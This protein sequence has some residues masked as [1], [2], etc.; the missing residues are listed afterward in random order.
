VAEQNETKYW[1]TATTTMEARRRGISNPGS[2]CYLIAP[3]QQL[4]N[5]SAATTLVTG[6]QQ[7]VLA[8]DAVTRILGTWL[9]E[10]SSPEK[11]CFLGLRV[12]KS[13]Y[14]AKDGDIHTQRDAAEFYGDLLR[15]LVEECTVL[16]AT[17]AQ[18]WTTA[19]TGRL[20]NTLRAVDSTNPSHRLDKE[21][22]FFYISVSVNTLDGHNTLES[23]LR[24]F[25]RT[26][27]VPFK[28]PTSDATKELGPPLPTGKTTKFKALPQLLAFHL[29]RFR[30]D[31]KKM[32]KEKLHHRFEFPA[33]LDMRP[34][35]ETDIRSSINSTTG[36]T[37]VGNSGDLPHAEAAPLPTGT[38]YR[39]S[40]VVVH[41]GR[42]AYSGHYYS[43][44]R[45]R[46]TTP[47]SMDSHLGT[48]GALEEALR[49]E[50]WHCYDDHTVTQCDG[51]EL[52]REAFGGLWSPAPAPVPAAPSDLQ[53]HDIAEEGEGNIDHTAPNEEGGDG[54]SS[55]SE[56]EDSSSSESDSERSDSCSESSDDDEWDNS[57]SAP[58][59]AFMLFYDRI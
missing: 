25:T 5:S 22:R 42:S 17:E 49:G 4:L 51:S 36:P 13:F 43:Y 46:H 33:L 30:F 57:P 27:T 34:Y 53:V 3:L 2:L 26:Q 35:M 21:E 7:D 20:Q 44:V 48:A 29:K 28:W 9:G 41:R 23:T 32:R 52:A 45:D 56:R 12:W 58:R 14:H 55:D 16:N 54:N 18:L 50:V 38:R 15:R 6:S 59:S 37:S 47:G 8:A 24:A 10:G 40:G 1:F 31:H 11:K 39:L 19:L